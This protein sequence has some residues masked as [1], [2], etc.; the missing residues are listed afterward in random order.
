MASNLS[1]SWTREI[2]QKFG[3][4]EDVR[5]R[6]VIRSQGTH[7]VEATSMLHSSREE[8][9]NLE[10]FH[11]DDGD[12]S[13][14]KS[15]QTSDKAKYSPK[16]KQPMTIPK[17]QTRQG[18]LRHSSTRARRGEGDMETKYDEHKQD[19]LASSSAMAT[20]EKAKAI[21]G[22]LVTSNIVSNIEKKNS[23]A[24]KTTTSPT[25]GLKTKAK[26]TK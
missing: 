26:T 6:E 16:L 15:I 14:S 21:E 24:R 25:K 22:T 19:A 5:E 12:L 23:R 11:L 9:N 8:E 20:R 2:S 17:S 3:A 18:D 10:A 13:R 7:N 1:R 4:D